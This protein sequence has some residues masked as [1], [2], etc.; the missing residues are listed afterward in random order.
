MVNTIV[1]AMEIKIQKLSRSTILPKYA[2]QGDAGLDLFSQEN[3]ILKPLERH[4]FGLGFALELPTGAVSLIWDKSGLAAKHG[5]H[6][7]GGVIDSGYRGEY[8]AIMVNL[9]SKPYKVEKGDKI[10]QLLIQ[11]VMH[12]TI[13]Q[14]KKLSNTSRGQGGFGSTGRK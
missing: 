11:P 9:G 5:I 13:K 2:Y 4:E 7:L 14:T 10:G 12:V 8:K 6:L 3:Y 1:L